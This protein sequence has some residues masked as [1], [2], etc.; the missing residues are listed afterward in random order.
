[1]EIDSKESIELPSNIRARG[2]GKFQVRFETQFFTKTKT[3]KSLKEA[4]EFREECL[5]QIKEINLE[6]ENLYR[7]TPITYND[8]G[9]AYILIE[10]KKGDKYECL[11]D[12]DKWHHL[13]Y[14]SSWYCSNKG[15]VK[16][17]INKEDCFIH[18]YL[19]QTYKPNKDISKL[20]LDHKNR[21]KLDNRI[22]NLRPAT[23]GQ[24]SYNVETKNK[25]GYRGIRQ[26]GNKFCAKIRHEGNEYYTSVFDTVEEAALAYNELALKYYGEEFAHKNIIRN[27]N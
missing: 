10:T 7:L 4:I 3:L 8:E 2:N 17:K 1:M 20:K 5:R 14:V 25:W 21:N 9:I 16:G 22:S 27:L 19:Y 15:Y 26:N 11:V 24:N 13:T 18:R 6:K 23:S 12:E